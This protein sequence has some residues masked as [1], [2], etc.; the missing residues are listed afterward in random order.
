MWACSVFID[1]TTTTWIT[2][3]P[4]VIINIIAGDCIIL[5]KLLLQ[6]LHIVDIM[7][8]MLLATSRI[9]F[10]ENFAPDFRDGETFF[11][12]FAIFFPWLVR[13]Y[14]GT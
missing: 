6:Q 4:V 3:A 9:P 11:S 13:I 10:F 8:F 12:V 2:L 1:K 5:I 14:P 7:Y